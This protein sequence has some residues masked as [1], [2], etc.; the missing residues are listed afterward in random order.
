MSQ[1]GWKLKIK[2]CPLCGSEE[3]EVR[4]LQV[5]P[6]IYRFTC[7]CCGQEIQQISKVEGNEVQYTTWYKS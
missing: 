1:K 6:F 5:I 4:Q 7:K 3:K 2:Y